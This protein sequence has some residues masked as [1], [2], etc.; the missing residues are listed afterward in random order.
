MF[1]TSVA[2]LSTPFGASLWPCIRLAL[3]VPQN[4]S[5]RYVWRGI[6]RKAVGRGVSLDNKAM[7]VLSALEGGYIEPILRQSDLG[8][9]DC[10]I[11][12]VGRLLQHDAP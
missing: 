7:S 12:P 9:V 5:I 6:P 1:V 11:N 8:V 10:P 3:K 2:D 4:V